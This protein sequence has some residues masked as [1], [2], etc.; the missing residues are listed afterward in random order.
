MGGVKIRWIFK[1]CDVGVWTG[2][3]WL[4]IGTDVGHL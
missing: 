4:R 2:P 1:K 3:I